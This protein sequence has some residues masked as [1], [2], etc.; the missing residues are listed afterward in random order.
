MFDKEEEKYD[1][2]YTFLNK[3]HVI[4]IVLEKGK[5]KGMFIEKTA[6]FLFKKK[7]YSY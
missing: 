7:N 6:K 2:D 1:F 5:R 3:I 4:I